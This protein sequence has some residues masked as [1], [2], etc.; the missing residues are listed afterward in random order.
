MGDIHISGIKPYP[1][2]KAVIDEL[3]NSGGSG[4]IVCVNSPRQKGKSYM[5]SNLLLYFAL[6]R[7]TQ[8]YYLSPTLKQ[9][10]QI[11]DTITGG[12]AGSG[13]IKAQNSVELNIKFIN[14][15]WI[16]CRSAE[17][18]DAL[19]G[20]C[21]DFMCIDEAA[22]IPDDIFY[23]VLPWADAHKAPILMAST[24][25]IKNGFF[26]KYF[27]FGKEKSHNTITIDWSDPIYKESIEK[28]LPPEKLEE[29]RQI[30]PRNVFL[31]E[32]LGHFL[33]DEGS[34][35]TNIKSCLKQ[36]SIT[37]GDRLYVGIDWSNQGQNDDTVV[38]IF[39][40]RGEQVYLK[41]FNN[42]TPLGQIDLIYKELE[43]Y[44]S[45][46]A[47]ISCE[48]NSLGTPYTDLLKGK[49][50]IMGNKVVGF[51]TSNTSKNS[52][53]VN[54]Q[55]ALEGGKATLLPEEK[56]INEFSYFSA[57]FNPKTRNITYG[58]PQGLHDDIVM[59]TLIAYDCLKNNLA[60]ANYSIVARKKTYGRK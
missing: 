29:Y 25:F 24:P 7:K 12:L 23:L 15:S 50:Q 16:R 53:V 36:T 6:N 28:I 30:L 11:W 47:V 27:C 5:V 2:Q 13:V 39:N 60:T 46:I 21:A 51:N 42:L 32:Y 59:A 54:F 35:F 20:Y 19:R 3:R 33:D 14:G 56:Q 26:Y 37:P 17:Q 58:A 38:S 57:D 52:I 48:T 1:H 8:C 31:S 45:Q 49:S 44:L 43:P 18:R 9:A 10:K 55:S 40:Q 41:Y 22:Y 34:V 4:K